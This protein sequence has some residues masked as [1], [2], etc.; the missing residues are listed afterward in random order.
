MFLFGPFDLDRVLYFGIN[1]ASIL[2]LEGTKGVPR[3]GGRK[4]WFERDF[5]LNSLHVQ[6]LMI[7]DV[8]TPFPHICMY[9]YIYM[10]VC[11]YI[12]IYICMYVY[13][14]IYIYIHTYIHIL[15]TPLV[16]LK[17][18]APSPLAPGGAFV[19]ITYIHIYIYI[20]IYRVRQ[21][22]SGSPLVQ[23]IFLD[24]VA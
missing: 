9:I 23:R 20:Y 19:T 10:Y 1:T 16:P 5:H 2:S 24:H 11:M 21:R 3:N 14:Y 4:S 13:I 15:G 18:R 8:Q 17:L 12:Y 6:T 22:I 7:T